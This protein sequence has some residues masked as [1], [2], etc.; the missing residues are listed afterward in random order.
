[1][2]EPQYDQE[3]DFPMMGGFMLDSLVRELEREF[4][5]NFKHFDDEDYH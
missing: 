3:N 5:S 2:R 1:M 4:S